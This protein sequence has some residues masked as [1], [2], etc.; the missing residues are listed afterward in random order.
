[1]DVR[2]TLDALHR[3]AVAEIG[4]CSGLYWRSVTGRRI[5]AG[6]VSARCRLA[7]VLFAGFA[8]AYRFHELLAARGID[9][10]PRS[11]IRLVRV[12]HAGITASGVAVIAVVTP[13]AR[14]PEGFLAAPRHQ[15]QPGYQRYFARRA[16][17]AHPAPAWWEHELGDVFDDDTAEAQDLQ[18][19][20]AY[21]EWQAD[22]ET[23]RDLDR[24]EAEYDAKLW[25]Y[26]T[27]GRR[28][29]YPPALGSV[30]ELFAYA[31]RHELP[32]ETIAERNRERTA[33]RW[34]AEQADRERQRLH[35]LDADQAEIA[36]ALAT[37]RRGRPAAADRAW[38]ETTRVLRERRALGYL[39][40]DASRGVR[41]TA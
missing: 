26:G 6:M 24:L 16:A 31:R 33:T 29:K 37:P 28:T 20:R 2:W 8:P 38:L 10:L 34:L 40:K 3:L 12:D 14:Q 15:H 23:E 13:D 35:D 32:I 30:A 19:G 41:H 18:P 25:W 39:F 1:M 36:A 7:Y 9:R 4:F 27:P 21:A 11:H 22:E 5:P 17:W